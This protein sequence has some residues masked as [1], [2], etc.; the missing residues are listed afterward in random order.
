MAKKKSARERWG[1]R[2]SILTFIPGNSVYGTMR[3][4]NA[5]HGVLFIL[6]FIIGFL[7][8][9]AKPLV[10]SFIMSLNAGRWSVFV[11]EKPSST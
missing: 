2:E 4:R 3:S 9:M 7:V 5:R 11:P 8:F 1:L 6:P 10:Q